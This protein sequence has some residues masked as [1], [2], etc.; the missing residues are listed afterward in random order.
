MHPLVLNQKLKQE[1]LYL[2]QEVQKD[3]V[4]EGNI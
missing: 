4:D 2:S 3:V 1:S